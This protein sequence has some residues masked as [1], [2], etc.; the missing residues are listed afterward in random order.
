VNGIILVIDTIASRPPATAFELVT[1][2]GRLGAAAPG[3]VRIIMA[4][5][6]IVEAAD[7]A[8]LFGHDVLGF[9]DSRF[10]YPNPD[11]L[12]RCVAPLVE[13]ERPRL[14]C[15]QHTMRGCQAAAFLSMRTGAPCITA[16]ESIADSAH[17]PALT[18]ALF[19]GKINIQLST[20]A[21]L[22]V[23]TVLPG[24]FPAPVVEA[25]PCAP[26]AVAITRPEGQ[27]SPYRP[28]SLVESSAESVRLEDADVIVSAGQGIGSQE[29]LDLIRAAARIFPNSAI[30]ASR[31]VCDRKWLPY[32][33]QVGVT[34][35]TVAPK[36][37]LACGISGAQQHIV[38][39]KGSQLIVAV[40][41]DPHAAIFDIAD[42]IIVEDLAKFLPALVQKHEELYS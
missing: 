23:L 14:V 21:G 37:Y 6:T 11:L 12:A 18:R 29:N 24:A 33:H 4:G 13:K 32:G 19:N 3:P 20:G 25:P 30:G 36:L 17:G 31:I 34:G 41:R 26:G 10:R 40:N 42:Y 38:G 27:D 5:E 16:V 28:I 9:E 1:C 39:M 22:A 15:F 7:H 35:K 8:A 2:A